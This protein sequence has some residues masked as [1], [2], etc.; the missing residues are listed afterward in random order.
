M[1]T[2]EGIQQEILDWYNDTDQLEPEEK[3]EDFDYDVWSEF[4]EALST[5]EWSEKYDVKV[6][7]LASGPA[8]LVED[9]GGE[10]QGDQRYVIF[11]IGDQFFKVEG[12]YSSWDGDYWEDVEPF[13]V[14]PQEVTVTQYSRKA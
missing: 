13:E 6:P 4:Y 5:K 12:S 14:F 2:A 1:A 10:G 11:S 7:A 8:Y 3:E 9:F